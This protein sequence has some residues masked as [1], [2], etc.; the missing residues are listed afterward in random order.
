[1]M[2]CTFAIKFPIIGVPND[3]EEIVEKN[4]FTVLKDVPE[5]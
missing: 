5:I 3:L 1:M 2:C 4:G